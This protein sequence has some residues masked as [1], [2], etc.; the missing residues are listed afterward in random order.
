MLL[1]DIE[2]KVKAVEPEGMSMRALLEARAR[3]VDSYT[4]LVRS[5]YELGEYNMSG[6][7]TNYTEVSD[8]AFELKHRLEGVLLDQSHYYLSLMQVLDDEIE[9]RLL[10][11]RD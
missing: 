9:E 11:V 2:A 10:E 5:A 1:K 7:A 6:S 4:Q 3:S 8:E